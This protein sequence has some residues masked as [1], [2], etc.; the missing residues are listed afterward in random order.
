MVVVMDVVEGVG[1]VAVSVSVDGGV[2]VNIGVVGGWMALDWS[3]VDCDGGCGGTDSSRGVAGLGM[4]FEV[5]L[6]AGGSAARGSVRGVCCGGG[7][8]R[9]WGTSQRDLEQV[10]VMMVTLQLVLQAILLM[11]LPMILLVVLLVSVYVAVGMRLIPIVVQAEMLPW[12]SG[13]VL[14]A[15][16][17]LAKDVGSNELASVVV[18]ASVLRRLVRCRMLS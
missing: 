4:G 13:L 2:S 8:V 1:N 11:I 12:G 15:V 17:A 14:V 10:L 5:G 9:G 3:A 6:R 7:E 16:V 18:K